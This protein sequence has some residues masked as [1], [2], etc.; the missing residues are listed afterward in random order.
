MIGKN[1]LINHLV[2][3]LIHKAFLSMT[4]DSINVLG[5]INSSYRLFVESFLLKNVVK[6]VG[7]SCWICVDSFWLENLS[8]CFSNF[9]K[10]W[11]SCWFSKEFCFF[12]CLSFLAIDSFY[13]KDET[14]LSFKGFC[15]FL[16]KVGIMLGLE[17]EWENS[18]SDSKS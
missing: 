14:W 13:V 5:L 4:C 18:Y 10:S 15:T 17:P 7:S 6:M 9:L 16:N 2:K 1:I 11:L 12:F 8:E 3:F